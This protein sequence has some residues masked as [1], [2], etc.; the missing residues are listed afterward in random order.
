MQFVKSIKLFSLSTLLAFGMVDISYGAN[1][2]LKL[3]LTQ[4]ARKNLVQKVVDRATYDRSEKGEAQ[5]NIDKAHVTVAFISDNTLTISQAKDVGQ[6][7]KAELDKQLKSQSYSFMVER[8]DSGVYI[9][10]HTTFKPKDSTGTNL[11]SLN[12]YMEK[13]LGQ[14]YPSIKFNALTTHKNYKPHITILNSTT[15]PGRLSSMNKKV[16]E[17]AKPH[18]SGELSFKLVTVSVAVW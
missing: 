5:K 12:Q 2:A 11:K 4:N 8:V 14:R 18:S 13:W 6:K 10:K 15:G 9:P 3:D 1:I 17:L 16:A 7:L